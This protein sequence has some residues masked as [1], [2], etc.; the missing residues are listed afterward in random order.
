M[1]VGLGEG[2]HGDARPGRR[3]LVALVALLAAVAVFGVV[4][5]PTASAHGHTTVGDY[6][7]VIGFHNEPAYQDQPNG[8]DLFVT[9]AKTGEKVN[10][11]ASTLKAELIYGGQ[12]KP[13]T[14]KP[15]YGK[16]G[17]YTAYVVPTA[18]GNY[19]WHIFGTINGTPA[20]VRME[21]SPKTFGAVEAASSVSFPA[22]QPSVADLH[23]Q[24]DAASRTA[25]IALIVGALGLVAGVA[26]VAFG[27][28]RGAVAQAN[29][30]P[31][32]QAST[33]AGGR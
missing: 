22:T 20:D 17:A 12:V 18:A 16:D 6:D 19:T 5:G 33:V 10:G 28:R 11:L 14:V 1:R 32:A 30:A 23:A 31:A 21:S 2:V 24:A 8:L 9:N 13:L 25:T 7:L 29:T 3:A 15:Q 26:G 4:G 27:L